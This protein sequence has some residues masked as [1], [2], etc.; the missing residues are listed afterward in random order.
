MSCKEH[1]QVFVVEVLADKDIEKHPLEPRVQVQFWLL[2]KHP[3]AWLSHK[4][5]V[6]Q[7]DYG[8]DSVSKV[9]N[10]T[11]CWLSLNVHINVLYVRVLRRTSRKLHTVAVEK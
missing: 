11:L 1:S 8:V 4:Q 10:L 7:D 9:I 2:D 6:H 3:G 5:A